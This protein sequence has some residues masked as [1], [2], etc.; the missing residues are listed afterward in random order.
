MTT[1]TR[2]VILRIK[3][4][5]A[6]SMGRQQSDPKAMAGNMASFAKELKSAT[7]LI[8]QSARALDIWTASAQ[9][10]ANAMARLRN[11]GAA[12][13]A[14]M[15]RQYSSGGN[16]GGGLGLGHL[17]PGGLGIAGGALLTREIASVLPALWGQKLWGGNLAKGSAPGAE[18]LLDMVSG[19]SARERMED[20]RQSM[21]D[22]QLRWQG[23][24][25]NSSFNYMA[26]MHQLQRSA[27]SAGATPQDQI[28]LLSK[29]RGDL[30]LTLAHQQSQYDFYAEAQRQELRRVEVDRQAKFGKLDDIRNGK[31][32]PIGGAIDKL[33][34]GLLTAGTG[35]TIN[36]EAES[37]SEQIR[38][39]YAKKMQESLQAQQQTL[40]KLL[41]NEQQQ[42]EI[43]KGMAQKQQEGAVSFGGLTPTEQRAATQ[44]LQTLNAGGTISGDE[45]AL[46]GRAGP[47]GQQALRNSYFRNAGPEYE[48]FLQAG[49]QGG[50][51]TPQQIQQYQQ[52]Q[53]AT[54]L[55]QGGLGALGVSLPSVEVNLT[56]NEQLLAQ[57]I[58]KQ[59]GETLREIKVKMEQLA[60]VVL[61]L[62][63]STA[64][65]DK[66]RNTSALNKLGR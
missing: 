50:Y 22:R 37:K 60:D 55:L 21:L 66:Q 61:N 4:E 7:P 65:K 33:F 64:G 42:L 19:R 29:Q 20:E 18:H 41:A 53:Q 46:L 34:G 45:Q 12:S 8:M 38:M 30:R 24:L 39:E 25:N 14:P 57:E 36:L 58:G 11:G 43:A 63:A 17:L 49:Q 2:E 47:I 52:G 48:N 9:K 6:R 23:G 32:E 62:E 40:E 59:V 51:V 16:G 26:G 28:D 15:Q 31:R 1:T 27:L 13:S 44:A 5:Q 3:T 35:G 54:N 10:A 56:L